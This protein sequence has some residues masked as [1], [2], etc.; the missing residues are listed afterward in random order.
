MSLNRQKNA[1]WFQLVIGALVLAVLA[2]ISILG[3]QAAL[4]T[5]FNAPGL[6][7]P[8]TLPVRA[9]YEEFTRRFQ[10]QEI[11]MISWEDC[12]LGS[13]EIPLAIA[14]LQ[15]YC[16]P[17]APVPDELRY[18]GEEKGL[19]RHGDPID[20]SRWLA[21]RRDAPDYL[22]L[23]TS[24]Q[25]IYDILNRPPAS[26][27]DQGIRARLAGA[28]VGPDGKQTCL[29]A[30]FSEAGH[31]LRNESLPRMAADVAKALGIEPADVRMAGPPIDGA[32]LD[33]EATASI[34]KFTLPSCV[35][36]AVICWLCLRS[37][38]L[39]FVVLSVAMIGQGMSLA[40]VHLVGLEMN[41]I[42]IVLPPLV[43]VLTASAGIH[44]SNYYLD[45]IESDPTIDPTAAARRAIQAG[46]VP[47]WLA[48]ITT[49][50]GLGS[51]G[52]VRLW[53][54]SAFGV[55]A[56]GSVLGTLLMLLTML[57]GAMQW[58]AITMQRR[59]L[60]KGR[61]QPRAAI[62][63]RLRVWLDRHWQSLTGRILRYP[64]ATVVLFTLLTVG[65]STGMPLLTTSV[66]VPRMFPPDSL[67]HRDYQW[68]EDH[69]GP[70]I[71]AELLVRMNRVMMPDI[72]EQFRLIRDLDDA[73]RRI[74][75]VGGVMSA[76]TFLP[77]PPAT[78]NRS[79]GAIVRETNIRKQIEGDDASLNRSGFFTVDEQ[80][81]P[82]WRVSFRFPFDNELDYRSELKR[83]Q[84]IV[85]E[86]IEELAP[87]DAV[88]LTYTGGIPMSTGS[89]DVLLDDLFRSFLAAFGVVAVVMILL[90][91]S[92]IG[93]VLAMFPN[94]FP[95]ITLFGVMGLI[96]MPLDIGSVMTA[97]VAL[98]IAVDATIHLLSRYSVEMKNGQTR[99]E[100]ATEALRICG[101]AMWQT[102]AVCAISLSV[103]GLSP[104]VPTQR[105]ALMMFGLL[106]AALIGD[107]FLMPAILASPL[108]KW[109]SRV[110]VE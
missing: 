62:D 10:G 11:V 90:L 3:S 30:T 24:G 89:Q 99:H 96:D 102:T 35:L 67:I 52:L 45:V 55:I 85:D 60:I 2:P 81:N 37:V 13:P 46:Y 21:A 63:Q 91:R 61:V 41:A 70:T 22:E 109:L 95:T 6:W 98:G 31:Y 103:Y 48:A 72:M 20:E 59:G 42:L 71:N 87:S 39:T 19:P 79:V 66:N 40:V 105:F 93:G 74:E 50:I 83:V 73:I 1:Y 75:G 9:E 106:S 77:T 28:L 76:R 44:L 100:A 15:K 53:P 33:H 23:L 29:L 65:T 38:L 84:D 43:F 8:E 107:V 51:L 36:G 104:F 78:E 69:L 82:I 34:E 12:E 17:S 14:A 58:H 88:S 110:S 80:G 16:V 5:M 108:G 49:M 25:A 27:S 86:L 54:V 4:S 7:L 92:V 101:P 68:F 97:S 94:L 26:F 64:I 32:L 56:A 57:P 47:C 18:L